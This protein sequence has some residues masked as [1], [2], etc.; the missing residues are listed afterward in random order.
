MKPTWRTSSLDR[1]L[2]CNGAPTLEQRVAPRPG[3][4]GDM[5]TFLHWL[6]HSKL[7]TEHGAVGEIGP[8][9]AIPPAI[10]FNAWIADYYVRFIRETVPDTWALECEVHLVEEFERFILSGHIDD[11]GINADATE[12]IIFDLKT[13]RDPV[14]PADN[15]DQVFGYACLLLRAYPTLRKIQAYIVQ[16]LADED[17]GEQRISGPMV[18]EGELLANAIAALERRVGAALDNAM[19]LNSSPKACK[20]CRVAVQCPAVLAERESMKLKL[21]PEAIERVKSTPD[22]VALAD[23]TVASRVLQRPMDD[24]VDAAKERLKAVGILTSSDGVSITAKTG[25]GVWKYPR[26]VE[27]LAAL[28]RHLG[29]DEQLAPVL[30]FSLSKAVDAIAA[31]KGIPKKAKVGECA[32]G[33]VAAEV[34]VTAEQQTRTTLQFTQ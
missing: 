30:G 27:T 5:G 24:A 12:A 11:C 28:R 10:E 17:S 21:T 6:A 32:E 2:L 7:K 18:M 1:N 29:T 23:W 4:E 15:N 25:P 31:A 14:D 26:P 3:T 16:P 33:I 34:K 22:D 13:G 9:P 19:E 8:S 20:W